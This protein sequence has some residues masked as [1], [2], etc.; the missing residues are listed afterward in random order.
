MHTLRKKA[1]IDAAKYAEKQ[2][3]TRAKPIA[4]TEAATPIIMP[5]I[6]QS[7]RPQSIGKSLSSGR[8]GQSHHMS[9][10]VEPVRIWNAPRTVRLIQNTN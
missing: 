2:Q 4:R 10:Y 3:R 6:P 1:R 7:I 8:S 9:M 5:M